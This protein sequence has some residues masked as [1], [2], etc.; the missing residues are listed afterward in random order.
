MTGVPRRSMARFAVCLWMVRVGITVFLLAAGSS[1]AVRAADVRPNVLFFFVDDWG[2]YAGIYADATAPSVNDIVRTPNIDRIGR[3]GVV[4]LNA[5]VPVASCSPCRASV[6]TGRY[7]WNCGSLAFLNDKCGDWRGQ[8]NP[9]TTMT[10][11]P[12]LLREAGYFARRSGKTLAFTQSKQSS[13][14]KN[15]P[16]VA[17]H[18]YGLHVSAAHDDAERRRRH[19]EVLQHPRQEMRRVLAAREPGQ[20]FFF[21][22]GTINA[23]RPLAAGSGAALWG[24][25]P[26]DLKGRLPKFL[27][28]VEDVRRDFTDY[29]GEVQAADAMLGAMLAELEAAGELDRTIVILSGDNGIPGIPRGKANCYDLSIRAPLL[30]RWPT[31]ITA[32]RRVEDFVSLMDVGPTLLELAGLPVPAEMDGRSFRRQLASPNSGWIDDTR[33]HVIVGRE[34]HHDTARDGRLPY[35][36]RA[37]RTRKLLFIRNFKPDRWPAGAPYNIDDLAIAA[38][39]ER[40]AEAPYRDVDASLTKSWLLAHRAE[41]EARRIVDL[42]LGMRPA[43]ELYDVVS[44]PDS[45]HN[46]ADDPAYAADKR[47]LEQQL[48]AV[49]TKTSDPRLTDAFDQPPYVAA[50]SS[51]APA[52][53][54]PAEGAV[55]TTGVPHFRWE[56]AVAPSPDAMP[57][58]AIQIADNSVFSHVIDED[59]IA[60]VIR[61]YLPDQEL[62]AGDYWWRIA[63]VD[64]AGRSGP[65]SAGR[66]FSIHTPERVVTVP[67]RATLK[68]I[69]AAAD[70]AAARTPA[71]LRFEP[72]E[73]RLD[74]G[75]LRHFIRLK[76][77]SDLTI[78]GSGASIIVSHP[79]GWFDFRDCRRILVKN[80]TVDIDPP[81]YTAARIVAKHPAAGTLEAEFLPGHPLPDSHPVFQRELKAM[82][83]TEADGFAMKRGISLVTSFAK[84]EHLSGRRYR[85]TLESAKAAR[86][87]AAGDIL[88]FDPR[89]IAEGGGHGSFVGGGEDVVYLDLTIRGAANECLGSFYADRHALLHVR[90]ER[91]PGRVL[92]VNNGGHNHHN[93]RTGPWV[94]G[95]SFE[96]TGDDTCHING[97]LMTV[98][99]QPEPDVLVIN[100]RQPYDHYGVDAELDIRPGDRLALYHTTRGRLLSEARVVSSQVIGRA[101]EVRLDRPVSGIATG[102]V[103]RSLGAKHA[104]VSPESRATEVYNLSRTCNQFVFRHNVARNGRRAGVIVKGD[105]GLVEDN[106]FENMGGGGV[107]LWPA[108]FEGLATEHY[109]IRRNTIL[110]CGRLNREHAGIWATMFKPG[111][112][113]LHSSILVADNRISGFSGTAILL[114]DMRD[115]VVRGNQIT[116]EAAHSPRGRRPEG[117]VLRNTENVRL[118]NNTVVPAAP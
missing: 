118:E 33:D 24:L 56:S 74:P 69:H 61:W 50:S 65:W 106:R 76:N 63:L 7:F 94:E 90:L 80:L 109:V 23:H 103:L 10:K 8:P 42:T 83:V 26:D 113:R 49:L 64:A 38:D 19:D 99:R 75:D 31:M 21:V 110:D 85:Y 43:E 60:A 15:T 4:F 107:E 36:S 73:Y 14:E 89:W 117:I 71:I 100:L 51:D 96:N 5:F 41:P 9:F 22:Y 35:P 112:D 11:F 12:D 39:Y 95:C 116:L 32:G 37:I 97:Y 79:V 16:E 25:R 1:A 77:V 62:P 27:P 34:N 45:L 115:A 44:D 72:G 108:P 57:S 46:L 48:L 87:L 28:D 88:A 20:P 2:R 58:Y 53:V 101:V 17:S 30:V 55:L 114:G 68:E 91:L 70:D 13:G 59:R 86:D 47:R 93:A 102:T 111:G 52:P 78:D 81:A 40:N 29:L 66:A 67:R 92:S 18:R 84:A 98:D 54:A 105:G 82:V 3:E 6:A 104:A